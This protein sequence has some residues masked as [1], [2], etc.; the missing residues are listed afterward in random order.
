MEAS[1]ITKEELLLELEEWKLRFES[2]QQSYKEHLA[3]LRLKDGDTHFRLLFDDMHQGIIYQDARGWVINANPAAERIL[4]ISLDQMQGKSYEKSTLKT[5]RED[6][7]E[8]PFEEHPAM[9]AI[10]TGNPV[11]DAVMGL[12]HPDQ[13][14]TTW[15]LVTSRPEFREPYAHPVRVYTTMTDITERKAAEDKLREREAILSNLVNSQTNYVLRTDLEG[16]Y[17]YWNHKYE[18]E[19]GW[20]HE[21]TGMASS[22]AIE[23]IC[24]HHHQRTRDVVERCLQNPGMIVKIELDKPARN[25]GVL[26]T[27]WEFVCLTN[28]AGN[29]AEIQCIGIDITASKEKEKAIRESEEKYRTLFHYSPDAYR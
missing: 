8:Y 17:T 11:E 24:Q 20:I 2:L 7:S 23:A 15:I 16:R 3:D 29:P 28:A 22:F 12:I 9:K 5:I 18:S 6:G 27:L 1:N 26:T 21:S 4:G 19:F 13:Q 14:K 25:G 10:H